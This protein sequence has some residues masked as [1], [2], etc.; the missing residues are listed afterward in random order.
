[1]YLATEMK[2]FVQNDTLIAQDCYIYEGFVLGISLVL[3][4][5]GAVNVVK[6]CHRLR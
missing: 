4:S 5:L 1:M 3:L 6:I 2:I